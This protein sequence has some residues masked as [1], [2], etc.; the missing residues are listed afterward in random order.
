MLLSEKTLVADDQITN[1]LLEVLK[2]S[3]WD[4]AQSRGSQGHF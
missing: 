1:E 3:W 2:G 4:L